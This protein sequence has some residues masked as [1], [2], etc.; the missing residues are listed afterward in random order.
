MIIGNAVTM[1]EK[2][3]WDTEVFTDIQRD[4]PHEKQPISYAAINVCISAWSL[5][6][7]VV[8]AVAERDG[9]SAIPDFR[10]SLDKWIPNQGKC[11]DIANTAKH[12]EHR[13]DR[14]KGGS[15]ELFWDD[16]DEDAPSAWALYH[17]DEDGNHALAFD[18]FS[19]LVNEWWQ[20]LVNVGLAEGKRPT[21]DWLR[22]KFQRIFGNIPVLPEPPIM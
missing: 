21:P 5:E 17:V 15:V 6:N 20:V 10:Q 19:S 7:W 8:K 9:R 12:A 18:V 22:M 3:L 2:L 4:F 13:D 11:A 16:L 1:W 14:W